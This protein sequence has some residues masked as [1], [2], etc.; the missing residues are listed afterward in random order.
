MGTLMKVLFLH[1]WTSVP[2]GRKPTYLKQHGHEVLNPALPDDDFEAAVRIAQSDYDQHRPDVIV[3]S[4]RGGA[5]AMNIESGDT[6]LVLLCPA[7]KRWGTATIVKTETMILHSKQDDV[8]PFSESEELLRLSRLPHAMLVEVGEDHRLADPEPLTKMLETCE[9]VVSEFGLV[10]VTVYYL[11]MR[12]HSR[13]SLPAPREG[14]TV[15]NVQHPSVSYYRFLYDAVGRDY[16]WTRKLRCSEEKLASMIQHPQNEL[17]VLHVDGSPAGYAELSRRQAD[18][19]ELVQ[20]GLMPNF[21]GQGLGKWLLQWTIDRVWSYEP[22][23]FWLHTC[24]MDHETALPFYQ[25]AGFTLYDE[26]RVRQVG[27]VR[28]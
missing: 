1:G 7:W 4:S 18:E 17:Y 27:T 9:R 21:I 11:E 26:Q 10:E 14:L 6:P 2:G 28:N 5:V 22:K 25:Q 15:L 19:I 20:F 12:S 13:R 24:T 23:R 8:I 3:G 16:Q